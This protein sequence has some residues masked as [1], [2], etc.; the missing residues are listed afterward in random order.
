MLTLKVVNN[1][2]YPLTV[3]RIVINIGIGQYAITNS[4]H[5]LLTRSLGSCIAVI[6]YDPKSKRGA[7]AHPMLPAPPSQNSMDL[8]GRYVSKVIPIL[9][10]KMNYTHLGRCLEAALIGGARIINIMD[11]GRRNVIKAREIL[12]SYGITIKFEDVGGRIVR[13]VLFDVQTGEVYVSRQEAK[14]CSKITML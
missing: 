1:N 6:L 14:L 4:D 5:M 9:L 7:L 3:G 2:L 10:E 12:K 11:I 8:E 13:S